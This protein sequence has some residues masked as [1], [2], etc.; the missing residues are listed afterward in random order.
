MSI[1]IEAT[2][3]AVKEVEEW[4][5]LFRRHA[6]L[7]DRI[8]HHPGWESEI[9]VNRQYLEGM[10]GEAAAIQG[11]ARSFPAAIGTWK[12]G[13]AQAEGIL[14]YLNSKYGSTKGN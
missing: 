2:R 7:L 5:H 1:D 14:E 11:I 6:E 4:F 13:I 8:V 3:Q 12:A 9:K 10:A